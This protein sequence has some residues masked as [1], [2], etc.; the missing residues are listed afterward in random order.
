MEFMRRAFRGI[1]G[2][3]S[4]DES[5]AG[6]L[7]EFVEARLALKRALLHKSAADADEQRRIAAIMPRDG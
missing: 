3:R 6:W 4:A 7:P 5:Q 2:Q 1:G